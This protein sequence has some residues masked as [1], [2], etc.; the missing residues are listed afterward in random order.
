LPHRGAALALAT[1]ARQ[2]GAW[3]ASAPEGVLRKY[4]WY[5]PSLSTFFAV[6]RISW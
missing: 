5:I 2:P 1:F 3:G 4:L 6:S